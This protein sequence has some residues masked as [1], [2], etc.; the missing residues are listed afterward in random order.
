MKHFISFW[1]ILFKSNLL[2]A[3]QEIFKTPEFYPIFNCAECGKLS[4]Y[5]KQNEC[6]NKQI[7]VFIK[8]NLK[9][10]Y[11]YECVEGKVYVRFIV[12]KNGNV[13][14]PEVAKGVDSKLNEEAI[15]VVNSFPKFCPGTY[16]GEIVE[17]QMVIPINFRIY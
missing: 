1:L 13:M 9:Y 14:N 7:F 8:D 3:Q 6:S 4:T 17:M 15:R 2:L 5:S 16:L 12:D 11:T 10:P